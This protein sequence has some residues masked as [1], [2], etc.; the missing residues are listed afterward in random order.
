MGNEQFDFVWV[1]N[2][3]G[4]AFPGGVFHLCET[5]TAWIARHKLTG[6]LT[7]YP[8]DIGSYDWAVEKGFFK[9]KREDQKSPRF[10]GSF[11]NASVEHYHFEE[12]VQVTG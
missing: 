4:S 11:S 8:V 3:E 1:F 12:G 9:P 7:K 5:A 6:C 10:I 2:G